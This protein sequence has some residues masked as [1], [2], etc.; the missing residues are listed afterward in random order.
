MICLVGAKMGLAHSM[1]SRVGTN[2]PCGLG[3]WDPAYFITRCDQYVIM[4]LV[5][6]SLL[7]DQLSSVCFFNKFQ[8]QRL[9]S[10]FTTTGDCVKLE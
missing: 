9:V 4:K 10:V 7:L 1:F 3:I 6:L 8:Q 5:L 2:A